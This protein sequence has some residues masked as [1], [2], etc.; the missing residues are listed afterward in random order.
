MKKSL[1]K[2][3][4]SKSRAM[5]SVVTV[6]V[7]PLE[8]VLADAKSAFFGLCVQTGKAVLAA[9]MEADRI[10]LCGA[11]GRPNADRRALRGGHTSSWVTLGGR[12]VA[13]RRPR[14]RAVAGEELSLES[15]RWAAGADPLNEANLAAIA[16]GVSTRRYASTLDRL[17]EA[18][19]QRS[20]S[21]SSVS[22]R[23]VA[24]SQARLGEWMSRPLGELDLPVIFVDGVHFRERMVLIALGIDAEGHKHVLGLR[25]GSTAARVKVVVASF[26]QPT[27][28]RC[29]SS[30]S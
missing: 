15:F 24:L 26:M 1:T 27:V 10:E 19:A 13:V 2:S 20:V 5:P 23:F 9:M 29:S 16:A 3:I 18:H 8:A 21:K 4:R 30:T 7:P 25:E 11:K 6:S 12:Q 14:A 17:P 22:R 28:Y